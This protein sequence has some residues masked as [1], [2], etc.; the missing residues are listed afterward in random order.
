MHCEAR[1]I[2]ELPLC[3]AERVS[4]G[5]LKLESR[6]SVYVGCHNG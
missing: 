5:E 3:V 6:R 1:L 2:L 4:G